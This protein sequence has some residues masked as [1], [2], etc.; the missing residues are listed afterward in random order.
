MAQHNKLV[1]PINTDDLYHSDVVTD[2]L[3]IRTFYEQQL[4]DRGLTIKYINLILDHTTELTEPEVEIE[5]DTYRSFS[6]GEIQCPELCN[7]QVTIKQN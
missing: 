3:E 6:R 2:I 1:T 7:P 4:L 5:F